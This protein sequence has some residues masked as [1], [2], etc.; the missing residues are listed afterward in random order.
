[1]G[2]YNDDCV[3]GTDMYG[4]VFWKVQRAAFL[5]GGRD[6]RVENNVFVDCTPAISLDGRGV[7]KAPVWHDMVYKTM[8]ERLE[9][10]NW[11]QPPYST[12]YPEL[13]DLE[14]LYER[15]DGI[16]PGKILVARNICVG[17][18]WTEI[19]WGA[20]PEMVRFQD[21]LVGQDPHFIDAANGNFAL[22]P[23]SPA[24]KLGFKAIPFERIGLPKGP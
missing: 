24:F 18:T 9:A 4:N 12:R 22:K 17:G 20:T 14:P 23:D 1:M 16:P 7:S 19:H 21:N 11:R 2:I 13:A 5:G 15:D 8:K 6:F 3:S 10:M